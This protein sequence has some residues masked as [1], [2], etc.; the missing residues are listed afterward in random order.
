MANPA[1]YVDQLDIGDA[2][3][4][5]AADNP[6]PH[7][8]QNGFV[9]SDG[10]VCFV[11][12]L[13]VQMKEDVLNS[14][15]LAQ[16]AATATYP[17]FENNTILWF[18]RYNEVLSNIGWV[19][20]GFDFERHTSHGANF[21]MEAAVIEFMAVAAA[22][23]PLALA[24]AALRALPDDGDRKVFPDQSTTVILAPL[25]RQL[26]TLCFSCFLCFMCQLINRN[27]LL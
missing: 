14:T 5:P 26:L 27:F 24:L 22:G 9:L 10:M 15:L 23:T 18:N 7:I 17:D 3:V 6:G 13:P 1:A 4:M 19:M 2:P 21:T 11:S 20:P 25:P 12:N 8:N 16:L